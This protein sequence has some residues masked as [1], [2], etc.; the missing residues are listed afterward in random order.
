MSARG[1]LD[2]LLTSLKVVAQLRAGGRLSTCGAVVEVDGRSGLAQAA[3]RWLRG[4]NRHA[5][6][7]QL[8]KIVAAAIATAA[9][10]ADASAER[11][12]EEL[13]RAAEG[14]RNL[15]L[16]YRTCSVSAAKLDVMLENIEQVTN[17]GAR[18]A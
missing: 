6:M 5:N 18:S 1:E 17:D 10:A 4:E 7:D 13:R 14:I 16:T 3:S 2:D 8:A 9:D 11:V 12:K 15:R